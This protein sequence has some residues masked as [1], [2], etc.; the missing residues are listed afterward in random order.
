[1]T[2]KPWWTHFPQRHWQEVDWEDWVKA[3]RP[4][5]PRDPVLEQQGQPLTGEPLIGAAGPTLASGWFAP[6]PRR[7]SD[8]RSRGVDH[9]LAE[10]GIRRR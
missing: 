9:L 3:G 7:G 8:A 6:K 1:V 5:V 2:L 4:K 10:L